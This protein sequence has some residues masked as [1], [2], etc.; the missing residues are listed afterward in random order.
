MENKNTIYFF[1]GNKKKFEEV[2]KIV[3]NRTNGKWEVKQIKYSFLEVQAESLKDVAL[4]KCLDSVF[5]MRKKYLDGLCMIDDS[6]LFIDALK[7]FPGVYSSYI[8]NCIGQEGILKLLENEKN[9]KAHF[10]C[11]I[12]IG[13]SLT[14]EIKLFEGICKGKIGFRITSYD[15]GFDGIFIPE[16]YSKT[17]GEDKDMKNAV[18]HRK[19]ALDKVIKYLNHLKF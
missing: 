5:Y 12:A 3:E 15:F 1:T 9:R 11:I 16:G 17:F 10:Q 18:S 7:G 19:K 2:K 6:G 4:K 13:N 8:M 14:G